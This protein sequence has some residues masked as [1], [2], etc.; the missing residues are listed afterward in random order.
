MPHRPSRFAFDGDDAYSRLREIAE[1]HFGAMLAESDREIGARVAREL[2]A[3]DESRERASG[4][5]RH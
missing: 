2:R 5:V 1:R 3:V 4:I